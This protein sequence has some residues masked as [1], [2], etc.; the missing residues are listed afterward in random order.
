MPPTPSPTPPT[1]APTPSPTAAPTEAP[2][3]APTKAPTH[4]PTNA[5]TV[6]P[7][8]ELPA[9]S[10]AAT[11]GAFNGVPQRTYLF[12]AMTSP[13]TGVRHDYADEM[14]AV[15]RTVGMKPICD[16]GE[17]CKDNPA[18]IFIGQTHHIAH[19]ENIKHP[20]Y[21]PSGWAGIKSKFDDMCM[22]CP[23]AFSQSRGLGQALCPVGGNSHDWRNSY[24]T[25]GGGA[26]Y[27]ANRF[28]CGKIMPTA[29]ST[30]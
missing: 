4:A 28:M 15:C 23:H 24:L 2:T 25:V 30:A 13:K 22:F 5:P 11:L 27:V 29:A 8:P 12:L 19:G 7:P 6:P 16:L 18:S 10:F 26:L 1:R 14:I 20:E 9:G 17:H 21:F 3:V